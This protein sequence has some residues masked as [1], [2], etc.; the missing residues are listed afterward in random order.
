M[1][2]LLGISN[3]NK[4]SFAIVFSNSAP[5]TSTILILRQADQ[6]T[7]WLSGTQG[8]KEVLILNLEIN[9]IQCWV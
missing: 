3:A 5:D 6:N 9:S 8:E 4:E 1:V 7:P 2:L